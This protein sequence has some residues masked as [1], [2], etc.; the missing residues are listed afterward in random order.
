MRAEFP[1]GGVLRLDL[2]GSLTARIL[3][4]RNAFLG[5]FR[6]PE[7]HFGIQWTVQGAVEVEEHS[8]VWQESEQERG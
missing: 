5:N 6:V 7:N 4:S 3:F 2:R 8:G 1:G